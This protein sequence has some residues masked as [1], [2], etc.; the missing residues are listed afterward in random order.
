MPLCLGNSFLWSQDLHLLDH[1]C[2]E[3]DWALY[4]LRVEPDE[5]GIEEQFLSLVN[6]RYVFEDDPLAR[7]IL[8]TDSCPA[9]SSLTQVLKTLC[10]ELCELDIRSVVD[11]SSAE[12]SISKHDVV[13]LGY[14]LPYMELSDNVRV[15]IFINSNQSTLEKV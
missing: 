7:I 4:H 3:F 10:H 14:W 11:A 6:E 9:L 13:L 12:L 15:D 2:L 8:A 5:L 1:Y